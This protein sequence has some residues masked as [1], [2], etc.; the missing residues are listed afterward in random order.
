[1]SIYKIIYIIVTSY[2]SIGT[3]HMDIVV[4]KSHNW[5]KTFSNHCQWRPKEL[6][7]TNETVKCSYHSES[8]CWF[9]TCQEFNM[10]SSYDK[11]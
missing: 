11:L 1:M 4:N 7:K 2:K 3:I 9:V 6:I 10:G 5:K 8:I